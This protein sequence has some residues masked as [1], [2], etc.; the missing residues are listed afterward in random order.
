MTIVA[1]LSGAG[2][3]RCSDDERLLRIVGVLLEL[4]EHVEDR[5][6]HLQR[7]AQLVDVQLLWRFDRSSR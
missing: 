1:V 6:L 3:S 5:L 7:R 2:A 4:W